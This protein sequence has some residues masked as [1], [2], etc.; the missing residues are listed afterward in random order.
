MFGLAL[1]AAILPAMASNPPVDGVRHAS[2]CWINDVVASDNGVRIYFRRK[3]GPLFVSL[4]D[5][6]FRPSDEP[7]DPTRP[8]EAAVEARVGDKLAPTNS[9]EDGCHLEVVNRNGRIGVE[10]RAFFNP[11]GLPATS[12]IE[13]IPA[14]D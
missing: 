7:I 2:I 5:Q 9:P 3:G 10:A 11:P 8:E 1:V 12:K 4:P 6:I 13:F 14:R